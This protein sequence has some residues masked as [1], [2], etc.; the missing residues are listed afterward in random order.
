MSRMSS[1]GGLTLVSITVPLARESHQRI[2]VRICAEDFGLIPAH[3][4][5]RSR[6]LLRLAGSAANDVTH[7]W[8]DAQPFGVIQIFVACQAAVDRL[9]QQWCEEVLLVRPGTRIGQ[10]FFAHLGQ[11]E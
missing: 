6:L 3:L 5:G 11:P 10:R 9:S 7:G 8:I 2:E 1:L 4:T